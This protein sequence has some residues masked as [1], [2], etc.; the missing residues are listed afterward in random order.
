MYIKVFKGENSIV[1]F[2][3]RKNESCIMLNKELKKIIKK[4]KKYVDFYRVYIEDEES[5]IKKFNLKHVPTL[6]FYK[7]RFEIHRMV[8]YRKKEI[9]SFLIEKKLM[10]I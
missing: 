8:G 2:S 10:K 4:Y 1:E 7:N 9:I 6:I 3:T 5:V